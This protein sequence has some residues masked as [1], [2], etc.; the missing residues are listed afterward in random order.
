[1]CNFRGQC[2]KDRGLLPTTQGQIYIPEGDYMMMI[3]CIALVLAFKD[4]SGL[5]G[6]YGIAVTGDMGFTSLLSFL[7]INYPVWRL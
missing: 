1:M 7:I 2:P 4:S 5:A 3:A 6:P